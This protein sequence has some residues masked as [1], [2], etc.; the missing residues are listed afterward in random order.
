MGKAEMII[1]GQF[2]SRIHGIA[3]GL[4][5]TLLGQGSWTP[6]GFWS[7][8][9]LKSKKTGL[10]GH[11]VDRVTAAA[12]QS[13]ELNPV[14][15]MPHFQHF[16]QFSAWVLG[17]Q[18]QNPQQLP[19][20]ISPAHGR[21]SWGAAQRRAEAPASRKEVRAKW[22]CLPE[23]AGKDN[24]GGGRPRDRLPS[25]HP[26]LSPRHAARGRGTFLK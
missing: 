11:P 15:L 16:V 17:A 18:V 12:Q 19:P 25:P 2:D 3:C 4:S 9:C 24:S 22:K 1:L 8:C 21:E 6:A 20:Q 14:F 7:I 10:G 26:A 13:Q 5:S 23:L